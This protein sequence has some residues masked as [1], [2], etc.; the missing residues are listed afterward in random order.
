M[1]PIETRTIQLDC[2]G[3]TVNGKDKVAYTVKNGSSYGS[4][5]FLLGVVIS[6]LHGRMKKEIRFIR[7]VLFFQI[8]KS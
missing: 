4:Y 1:N 2:N 5:L 3:G 7:G 6:L 8:L